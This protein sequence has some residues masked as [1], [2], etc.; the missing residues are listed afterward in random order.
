[1]MSKAVEHT[2]QGKE[3]LSGCEWKSWNE[4]DQ[5]DSHSKGVRKAL[6]ETPCEDPW[7]W[8]R[9]KGKG[10]KATEGAREDPTLDGKSEGPESNSALMDSL[11]EVGLGLLSCT[12]RKVLEKAKVMYTVVF[13]KMDLTACAGEME[14]GRNQT[15]L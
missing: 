14:A 15:E 8:R 10:S 7:R 6:L 13:M 5:N 1:M 2:V 12:M 9:G 3:T 11:R 4:V